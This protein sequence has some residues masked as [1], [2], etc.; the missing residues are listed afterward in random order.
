MLRIAV[1]LLDIDDYYSHNNNNN[2]N[3]NRLLLS[4]TQI[5]FSDLIN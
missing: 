2:N 5:S 3:N 4:D 1:M